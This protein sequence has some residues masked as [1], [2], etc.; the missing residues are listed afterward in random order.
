MGW[1][2]KKYKTKTHDKSKLSLQYI[3]GLLQSSKRN[4]ERICEVAKD[5]EYYQM[6]H[7]ISESPW[8]SRIAMDQI[9]EDMSDLFSG[10]ERVGLLLD[11]SSFA[12]KGKESVGVGRQYCGT[13]GKT[14]NCQ[15]AVFAALSTEKYYGLIDTELYLPQDWTKSKS[16]LK[17]SGVP[18][19]RHKHKTKL[20]LALD[21]IK[22]QIALDVRFDYIAADGFYGDDYKLLKAIDSLGKLF[23]FDI[24]INHNIYLAPPGIFIPQKGEGQKGRTPSRYKTLSESIEVREWIKTLQNDD[25][26]DVVIR[27]GT[28]GEI[29]CK[30]YLRKVYTWDRKSENYCERMLIIRKTI[31]AEGEEE[32]KYILSNAKER[33]YTLQELI[34]I[35]AQRY[36]IERSFQE[37]KQDI[38]ASEYQIRGWLAWHHHMTLCMQAQHFILEE[39]IKFKETVPLLSAYDVRQIMIRTY[40]SKHDDKDEVWLQMEYRHK[41]RAYDIKEASP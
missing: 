31:L 12:K 15:V 11:E 41:Q 29:K 37:V 26:E 23:V 34:E 14:D 4:I 39:K 2:K 28:K 20:E 16:K 3:K 33:E 38:G 27:Q 7:F 25:W 32:I 9:A 21:I 30:A 6:Q 17:K 19:E 1:R 5:S 8:D 40:S 10:Y 35:Q 24:H 18:V 13:L 22:R 36:F